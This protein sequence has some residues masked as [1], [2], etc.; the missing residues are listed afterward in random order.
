MGNDGEVVA[1][2]NIRQL[3]FALQ[4]REQ[5]EHF[6]LHRNVQRRGRLVEQKDLRLQD[7]GPGHG[8]ALPLATGELVRIAE[9]KGPVEPHGG[10]GVLHPRLAVAQPV[11]GDRFGQNAVDGMPGVE[12]SV[13][14][15]ENH[16]H[17]FVKGAR[18]ASPLKPIVDDD[19]ARPAPQQAAQDVEQ[20]RFA[21]T[22]LPHDAVDLTRGDI[23]RNPAKRR[24]GPAAA[25][26]DHPE[27]A[28]ADHR[29]ASRQAGSRASTGSVST[30]RSILGRQLRSPRV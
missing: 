20:G 1:D 3:P 22:R 19:L 7:Q 21:R 11:N 8:H 28:D 2:Q 14:V 4:A 9:T 15:L 10:Q 12:R 25:S 18:P 5:V 29:S 17:A 30:G 13:R 27:I 26:E 23:E 16:L 24:L 6:R